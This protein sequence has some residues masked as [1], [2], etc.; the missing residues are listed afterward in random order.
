MLTFFSSPI[1]IG[2]LVFLIE[3]L[4]DLKPTAQITKRKRM[5]H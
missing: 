2:R 1:L 5:A 3:T 4:I